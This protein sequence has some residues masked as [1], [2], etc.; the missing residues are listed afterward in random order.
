MLTLIAT[1]KLND[2]APQASLADVPPAS[3]ICRRAASTSSRVERGEPDGADQADH[4]LADA[5]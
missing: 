4:R 5:F 3:P 2:A 1:A